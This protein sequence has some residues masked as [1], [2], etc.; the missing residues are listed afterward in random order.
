MSIQHSPPQRQTRNQAVL[1]P[2]TRVPLYGTPEVPKLRA[3]LNIGPVIEGAEPSRKEGRGP[4]RSSSLSEVVESFP[5]LSRNTFKGPA[6][7]SNSGQSTSRFLLLSL[8]TTCIKAPDCFDATQPF[9]VRSLIQSYQLIFYNDKENFSEDRKKVLYATS[10]VI[11]RAAKWIEP[12][13][14]KITNQNPAYL[15]N[16]WAFFEFQLFNL[17]GDPNEVRKAYTEL[18]V[19]RMKEGGHVSLYISDFRSIVSRIGDCGERALIHHFRKG[20]SSRILDITLK[21]DTRYH[22]GQK[23]KSHHQEKKSE[24]SKSGSYHPQNPS[25]L[26]QKEKEEISFSEEGQDPFYFGE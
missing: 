24:A 12:Y 19:L 16:N 3:H 21:L 20:M 9:K 8:K 17:L 15:H 22:E 5:G 25:S 11:G 2:T 14:S 1:T 4:R 23:K 26:N 6:D 10:F 18:D 13:P 7:D